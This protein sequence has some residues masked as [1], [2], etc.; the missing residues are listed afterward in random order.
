MKVEEKRLELKLKKLSSGQGSSKPKHE[1]KEI[2]LENAINTLEK[3]VES[4]I[5]VPKSSSK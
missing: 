4:L 5:E 2:L 3:S 1:I